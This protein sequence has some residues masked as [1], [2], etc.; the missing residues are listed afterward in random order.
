MSRGRMLRNW[1]LTRTGKE[2]SK[3]LHSWQSRGLES[4]SYFCRQLIALMVPAVG[5]KRRKA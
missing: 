5:R 2:K 3:T 1:S 4:L